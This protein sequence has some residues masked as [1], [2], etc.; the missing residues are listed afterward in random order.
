M[1]NIRQ[2]IVD[3][4]EARLS[5]ISNIKTVTLWRINDLQ[6]SELPAIVIRDTVD[7]M[8]ADGIIGR[9]DHNLT[10]EVVVIFSGSTSAEK[11]REGIAAVMAA[12]GTDPTFGGLAYD[13]IPGNASMDLADSNMQHSAAQIDIVVRYRSGLWSI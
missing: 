10:V 4:I 12:I 9:R 1:A 2:D 11:V 5:T 3:A 6:A 7:D 13:T 8:P